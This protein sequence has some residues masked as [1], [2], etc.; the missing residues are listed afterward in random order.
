MMQFLYM[1]WGYVIKFLCWCYVTPRDDFIKTLV[2]CGEIC[3]IVFVMLLSCFFA[4]KN[5]I[6]QNYCTHPWIPI[7]M[8]FL[9]QLEGITKFRHPCSVLWR[10]FCDYW[11]NNDILQTTHLTNCDEISFYLLVFLLKI[12]FFWKCLV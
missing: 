11:S 10:P 7:V 9:Y 6:L 3:S 2:N 4:K 12:L 8:K 5:H 1:A